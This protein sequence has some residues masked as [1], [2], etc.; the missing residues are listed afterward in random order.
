MPFTPVHVF[1][2]FN[3]YG[4]RGVIVA[5]V[6]LAAAILFVRLRRSWSGWVLLIG[7]VGLFI[8]MAAR[9]AFEVSFA[10]GWLQRTPLLQGCVVSPALSKPV[11]IAEVI[12]YFFW[13]GLV[14][15]C[16]RIRRPRPNHAMERTAG[17]HGK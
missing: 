2:V 14:W 8:V 16:V 4:V 3:L 9:Y 10:Q 11:G 6:I 17:S 5:A 7:A 15:C 12:S 13:V 1:E